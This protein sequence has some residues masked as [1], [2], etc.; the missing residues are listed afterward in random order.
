MLT[1]V[2]L[3]VD[4]LAKTTSAVLGWQDESFGS[5]WQ[6]AAGQHRSRHGGCSMGDFLIHALYHL[7]HSPGVLFP[8]HGR[9]SGGSQFSC[10]IL[11]PHHL[12][13]TGVAKGKR[14][15]L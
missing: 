12:H 14:S 9:F 10:S 7:H 1:T 5:R 13:W 6:R 4:A 3:G 8:R 15:M 2:A 11:S